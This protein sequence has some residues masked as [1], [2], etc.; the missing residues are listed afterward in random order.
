M[1]CPI[2]FK[3]LIK[4]MAKDMIENMTKAV[5]EIKEEQPVKDVL[6]AF[7]R[8]KKFIIAEKTDVGDRDKVYRHL[9]AT[10]SVYG[11]QAF[12]YFKSKEDAEIFIN[13]R[14]DGYRH[15]E[16]IEMQEATAGNEY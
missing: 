4:E 9:L 13:A 3:T 5:K 1:A 6:N 16:V 8:E 2:P 7:S 14:N 10:D 15:F 11:G 12:P